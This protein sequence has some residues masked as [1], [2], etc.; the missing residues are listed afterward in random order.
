MKMLSIIFLLTFCLQG[1]AQQAASDDKSLVLK[2][3]QSYQK[4]IERLDTAGTARL[5][6]KDSQ[7]VES[8]SVEGSYEHYLAHH[9]GPEL[10]DFTSFAF[11][12]Y[13]VDVVIDLPYA[14]TTETYG[15]T[16]VLKKDNSIAK[17]K[18]VATTV[19]KKQNGTWKIWQT[20]TSARKP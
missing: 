2:T 13:K 14:F 6:W 8:G 5:F 11:T 10:K 7:V 17:R 18:G 9:L 16:I 3:M 1:Q 20:H 15:Y 12:D 19:L 4:A